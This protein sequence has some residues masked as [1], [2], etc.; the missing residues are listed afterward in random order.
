MTQLGLS[1]YQPALR[2]GE[3]TCVLLGALVEAL[4]E[5]S[6]EAVLYIRRVHYHCAV[7]SVQLAVNAVH[8][9]LLLLLCSEAGD[10]GPA[11][12]IEP[13][14]SLRISAL[15]D[16][17]AVLLVAADPSVLVPA[18]GEDSIELSA[19]LVQVLDVVCI[20]LLNCVGAQDLDSV[21]ELEC[22]EGGLALLA[23]T[24]AVVPVS[25]QTCG[26]AVVAEVVHGEVD[27]SLEV[28]V[29]GALLAIV[30]VEDLLVE[31]RGIAALGDVLVNGREQ[32]QSVVCT[33]AGVTSLLRVYGVLVV[34]VG[35]VLLTRLVIVLNQRQTCAV[36]YLRGQHE[37]DLLLCHLRRKVN[38]TLDILNGVAVAEAVSQAAVLE[39]SRSGPDEGDEAVVC[40]PGV[41]HVVEVLVGGVY[42]E[43]VQ[44]AVPVV[45]ELCKLCLYRAGLL[46]SADDLG[47][48]SL[49]LLA[50][51][52]VCK[53]LGLAGLE[54]DVALERANGVGVVVEVA[55]QTFL[56]A[57]RV[58]VASVGAYEG[59][60]VAAVSVYLSASQTE[61]S[62]A[63]RI[64][65]LVLHLVDIVTLEVGAGDEQSV[66]KIYLILLVVRVVDE[67]AYAGNSELSGLIGS[68]CYLS[69]PYL[70]CSAL[71]NIV[72]NLG[73]N[74]LVL[75][76]DNGVSGTVAALALE[77]IERLAY[78]RPGSG[79]VVVGLE[80]AEIYV[81]AG[82]VGAYAVEAVA[83]NTT[84]SAALYEAV[85]ACV[86]G[87]DSAVLGVAEVVSPC[88]RCVRT[89][90]DILLIEFVEMTVVHWYS[91]IILIFLPVL[92]LIYGF[93]GLFPVALII[94]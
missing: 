20:V 62:A 13:H 61:E 76:S 1:Q 94:L 17:G 65:D 37:H 82:G 54:N 50:A 19:D 56:D 6:G 57:L 21:Y 67:L 44:L 66:L 89:G 9:L 27:R 53:L 80:V 33:V 28:V 15:T 42:L 81:S 24:E 46:V 30:S 5:R 12:R 49:G 22:N 7:R 31:E 64:V 59:I 52:D 41:N 38:D 63:V 70:V 87:D 34:L 26:H 35:V 73:L 10:N 25:V 14:G 58:G 86:V 11:L 18:G 40:V 60:S 90:D 8:S 69:S 16:D 83:D 55:L 79:P 51:E 71:G 4:H 3:D 39:G 75:G 23:E 36:S 77:L 91:S 29:N 93:S 48:L 88:G 92:R 74:A 43:V 2:L 72:S 84:V 85:A 47:D 32:P 68:V 45:L 78:G